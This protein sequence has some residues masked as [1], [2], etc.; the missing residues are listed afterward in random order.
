MQIKFL[1]INTGNDELATETALQQLD[2]FN[3]DIIGLQEPFNK[4]LEEA[5]LAGFD[6]IMNNRNSRAKSALCI[7]R[8][9]SKII[10]LSN[11]TNDWITSVAI[12]SKSAKLIVSSIYFNLKDPGNKPR[13]FSDDL[14]LVQQLIAEFPQENLLI[15]TDSNAR[16]E[17][18]ADHRTTPRGKE[19]TRFINANGLVVHNDHLQGPTY[20]KQMK[21]TAQRTSF[22]D[23]TLTNQAAASKLS[24]WKMYNDLINTQHNLITFELDCLKQQDF[25]EVQS[26]KF[27]FK[28]ANLPALFH[29]FDLLKPELDAVDVEEPDLDAFGASLLNAMIKTCKFAIP[30]TDRVPANKKAW[31]W[32]NNK[33]LEIKQRIENVLKGKRRIRNPIKREQLNEQLKHLNK[34]YKHEI[35]KAKER[36]RLEIN[37]IT[38]RDDIFKLVNKGRC[39]K[40]ETFSTFTKQ[41]GQQTNDLNEIADDILDK[42]FKKRSGPEISRTTP[43]DARGLEP[44]NEH[45]LREILKKLKNKKAPGWDGIPNAATKFIIKKYMA[46]FVSVFNLLLKRI[47]FPTSW[48]G[49]KLVLFQKNGKKLESAASL[50]PIILLPA[51]GKILEILMITRIQEPLRSKQF[52]SEAQHGFTRNK[53]TTSAT[54]KLIEHMEHAR[55]QPYGVLIQIDFS[56][57]FDTL[58]WS[59]I[60]QNLHDAGL[61]EN[62]LEG[63]KELLMNRTV[64]YDDGCRRLTRKAETGCPQG[65]CASP[66]LWLIGLNDMLKTLS[67]RP[68]TKPN[69]FADDSGIVLF[70]RNKKRFKKLI[71][72]TF[73]LISR[74]CDSSGVKLNLEKTTALLLGKR[75]FTDTIRYRSTTIE[76]V[77]K[78]K[79]L[80]MILQPNLRF[81]EHLVYI[82]EKSNKLVRLIHYLNYLTGGL[83]IKEKTIIYKQVYLVSILYGKE[84]WH[85]RLNAQQ[86][87]KLTSIQRQAILA[88]SGA[89]PTTNNRKLLNLLGFLE[90]NEEAACQM[91]CNGKTR[92]ERLALRAERL[93]RQ[94]HQTEGEYAVPTGVEIKLIRR[95]EALWFIT[96]HGPFRHHLARIKR[97]RITLCRFC[98]R[99]LETADHL[100]NE[101][102]DFRE[103]IFSDTKSFEVVCCHIVKAIFR[104]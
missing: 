68:N 59:K 85:P 100:L 44:T 78:T 40:P 63:A 45:E 74:W 38:T 6:I 53:N 16:H 30:E 19:F 18:Y 103:L 41:N 46:Y 29:T 21:R 90:V 89:F 24:N 93:S 101:C 8:R 33:I 49:G 87:E 42:F 99:R 95:R 36:Y 23:F 35:E 14:N 88:V 57:A 64:H 61:D 32:S 62:E 71:N 104:S 76:Y 70:E 2:T 5:E 13:N 83:S 84:V 7:R 9:F 56:N 25:Y 73:T 39:V 12:Q 96:T 51:I 11:Y 75:E 15:M 26:C 67:A 91:E 31:P 22:I 48:K 69:A 94:R 4:T 86:R 72:D 20:I 79:F 98:A 17:Q 77:E 34:L 43:T 50:R 60:I 55:K 102:E 80:G 3:A 66:E 82:E 1:Q 65:S 81:G 52:Y 92:E 54:K 58:E 28:K 37:K 47:A 27:N 97:D 10:T